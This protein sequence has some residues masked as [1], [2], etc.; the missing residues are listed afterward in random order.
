MSARQPIGWRAACRGEN[1]RITQ[2]ELPPSAF[3]IATNSVHH[4]SMLP[5]SRTSASA[6]APFSCAAKTVE[7][8]LVQDHGV[9]RDQFFTVQ[10]VDDDVGRLGE[11]QLV[12]LRA[13]RVETLHRDRRS[14]FHSG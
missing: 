4:R 13:D 7:V 12:H 8:D 10:A 9:G 3:P 11:I 5:E 2:P 14:C 1:R 6:S